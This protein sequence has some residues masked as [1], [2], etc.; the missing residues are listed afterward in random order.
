MTFIIN[1]LES[2]KEF[3]KKYKTLPLTVTDGIIDELSL[4]KNFSEFEKKLWEF[5]LTVCKW[6]TC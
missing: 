3:E 1:P 5:S 2:S 6:S 4:L